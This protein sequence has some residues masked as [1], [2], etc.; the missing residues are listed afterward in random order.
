MSVVPLKLANQKAGIWSELAV[1]VCGLGNRVFRG[2]SA[3]FLSP[4]NGLVEDIGY[5]MLSDYR[6]CSEL[7][8]K[9]SWL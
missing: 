9:R 1:L 2:V 4:E 3:D 5:D 7:R 8:E 6:I